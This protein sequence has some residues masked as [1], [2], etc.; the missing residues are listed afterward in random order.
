MVFTRPLVRWAA[1]P[2]VPSIPCNVTSICQDGA[3]T[4]SWQHARDNGT[5]AYEIIA[6]AAGVPAGP[7]AVIAAPAAYGTIT[8]LANSTAYTFTVKA[9]NSQGVSA[10]SQQSGANTPLANLLFGDDFN[11]PVIDPAWAVFSRD[12][13]Q[14]NTELEYYL[15]QQVTLDGSSN[16]V[17]TIAA[18]T[19]QAP[20]YNDANPPTYA[21]ALVTRSYQS[22]A[23]QWAYPGAIAPAW[24]AANG[25]TQRG[26]NFTY[27]KVQVSAKMPNMGGAGFQALW[28]HGSN[29]QQTTPLNPDNVGSCSWPAA[30]SDEIDIA[31]WNVAA[32]SSYD[33][34]MQSGANSFGPTTISATNADTTYHTYEA[35]WSAGSL[36]WLLDG[37][38]V[39]GPA[40]TGVPSTGMTLIIDVATKASVT[41]TQPSMF[42]DWVRVFHN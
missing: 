32:V 16:L 26:F 20:T 14:S 38:S 2:A 5:A 40:S 24:P 4:V 6:Y 10:E 11:G 1:A 17:L 33:I 22:G 21:G 7:S 39:A 25:F 29:C 41:I 13:D 36:S 8:G 42:V 9:A 31:E 23:V 3:A 37:S 19:V 35:D 30:G 27:G 12:G 18:R 34:R 28:M 15:P